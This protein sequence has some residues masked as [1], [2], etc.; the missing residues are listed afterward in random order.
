MLIELLKSIFDNN[1][2][3]ESIVKYKEY[4]CSLYAKDD[5]DNFFIVL[6]KK[7]ITEEELD[8]LISNGFSELYERLTKLDIANKAFEKNTTLIFCLDSDSEQINK[9]EED[10]YLFK[11]NVIVYSEDMKIALKELL[12]NDYSLKN[13]NALLNKDK[14]F[15][16]S[17]TA[18]SN[19]Y[20]L[21]SRLFIKLPFLSY[22]RGV[23]KLDNLSSVI[24]NE[25]EKQAFKPLYEK[26]IELDIN[27]I[28][29]YTKL[30]EHGIIND[31]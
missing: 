16:D 26:L 14:L 7:E 6:D 18:T 21:L 3:S 17:K 29:D 11:K 30:I 4:S 27:N 20:T 23:R 13:M 24:E 9:I 10:A 5:E 15:E 19:S 25:A 31:E 2:F 1:E 12:K 22:E 8:I 28:T